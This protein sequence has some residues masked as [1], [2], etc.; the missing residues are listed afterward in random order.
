[1]ADQPDIVGRDAPARQ[2]PPWVRRLAVALALAAAAG[3]FVVT[4]VGDRA[5]PAPKPLA[6]IEPIA[7]DLARTCAAPNTYGLAWGAPSAL[8][9]SEGR[10]VVWRVH[11]CNEGKQ[12]VTVESL[13]PLSP[14]ERNLPPDQVAAL[15]RSDVPID[16]GNAH[17]LPVRI[18]PGAQADVATVSVV[19]GCERSD[20]DSGL[21]VAVR[22]GSSARRQDMPVRRPTA[23]PV[24]SWCNE[25]GAGAGG[26]VARPL[27]RDGPVT[28]TVRASSI[29]IRFPLLNPNGL[30]ITLT[31]LYPPSPGVR[32]TAT[33]VVTL[34]AGRGAIASVR[35]SVES[36]ANVFVEAAWQL[37]FR[38]SIAGAPALLAPVRLDAADWQVAALRR[39]CPAARPLATT[40]SRPELKV[41][42]PYARGDPAN[43][44]VTQVV[45]NV[46]DRTL[47]LRA[48][49]R[50]APGMVFLRAD[51]LPSAAADAAIGD[52]TGTSMRSWAM[53]P[54]DSAFLTYFYRLDENIDPVCLG[55]S[56]DRWRAPVDATDGAGHP[57]TV[58]DEATQQPQVPQA[59]VGGWRIAA[60][61]G[62]ARPVRV[63]RAAP[64][65]VF[66]GPAGS[67][68]DRKRMRY[69]L[70]VYGVPGEPPAT[71]TRVRLVGAFAQLQVTT[72][73][74]LGV[75]A[76][77]QRRSVV[78]VAPIHC[79]P[80]GVP[81]TLAVSY[82]SAT[83]PQAPPVIVELAATPSDTGQLC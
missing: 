8:V 48:H 73:P 81:V 45:R 50:S 58:A 27:L 83:Q 15:Q 33:S 47:L 77:E 60:T 76:A 39:I 75:I 36:C 51:V 49:P 61:A 32:V 53:S 43:Y 59:W 40:T 67:L 52:T 11:L 57:V 72:T 42:G 22:V 24:E 35:L 21:S 79:P 41:T 54:G 70:T 18:A 2:V 55:P 4:Q 71:V 64:F 65:L 74:A 37:T 9:H 68:I 29:G 19:L 13:R 14:A 80:P 7:G 62:C 12:A 10:L 25:R 23:V 82:R 20:V 28:L 6:P 31:G 3:W 63:G 66:T 44:Q 56:V 78:V 38:G 16:Q 26:L 46:S 5:Q 17:A 69:P 30:P 34:P 1:M